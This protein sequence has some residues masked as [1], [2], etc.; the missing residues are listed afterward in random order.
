MTTETE[1]QAGVI[2]TLSQQ[3]AATGVRSYSAELSSDLLDPQG[4]VLDEVI[5]FA[6]DTLQAQHVNLRVVPAG[7]MQPAGAHSV[8]LTGPT[9]Y[10]IMR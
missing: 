1:R 8:V 3:P 9:S 2:I 4:R 10:L 7:V 5:G 6:F